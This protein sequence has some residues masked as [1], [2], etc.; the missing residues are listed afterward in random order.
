MFPGLSS[1]TYR[2]V[3][4]NMLPD[5]YDFKSNI[6]TVPVRLRTGDINSDGFPDIIGSYQ[7]WKSGQIPFILVNTGCKMVSDKKIEV[8]SSIKELANDEKDLP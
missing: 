2:S 7:T 1:Q 4:N 6:W 8:L 5:F 3:F